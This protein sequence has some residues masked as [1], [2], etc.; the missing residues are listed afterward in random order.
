MKQYLFVIKIC[1]KQITKLEDKRQLK[2]K[3]PES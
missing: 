1:I 2:L 3:F